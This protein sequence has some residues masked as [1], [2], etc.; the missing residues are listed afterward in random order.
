[1]KIYWFNLL[2]FVACVGAVAYLSVM[3]RKE[4]DDN[5]DEDKKQ[6][7]K[8]YLYLILIW[9]LAALS[10]MFISVFVYKKRKEDDSGW[11]YV[12]YKDSPMK[13]KN[14]KYDASLWY[15]GKQYPNNVIP[16][17]WNHLPDPMNTG[18]FGLKL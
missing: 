14:P 7:N 16:L 13:F 18:M 15:H 5:D 11:I 17:D 8:S 12:G 1:M 3:Y 2:L 4:K 9:V 6:N 10:L